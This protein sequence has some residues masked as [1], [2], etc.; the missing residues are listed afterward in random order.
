MGDLGFVE[1]VIELVLLCVFASLCASS[2]VIPAVAS[3]SHDLPGSWRRDSNKAA[4]AAAAAAEEVCPSSSHQTLHVIQMAA[5]EESAATASV[6][7]DDP[8][9]L[10]AAPWWL[11]PSLNGE[12]AGTC[13]V[14]MAESSPSHPFIRK[15]EDGDFCDAA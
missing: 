13:P 14:A 8:L 7:P 9:E 6:F 3:S 2:V 11:T 5:R 10:S 15:H 12:V 4:A 1:L